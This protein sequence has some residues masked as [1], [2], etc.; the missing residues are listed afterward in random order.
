MGL[1][2][3][4]SV[5][6]PLLLDS[7]GIV[8]DDDDAVHKRRNDALHHT[9]VQHHQQLNKTDGSP[10]VAFF[11]ADWHEPSKPKGQMDAVFTHLA[12]LHPQLRFLRVEAEAVPE[13]SVLFNVAVVPTFVCLRGG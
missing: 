8:T 4:R 9:P 11:W 13:V 5:R 2:P 7:R 6:R 3:Q 1:P 10:A 12:S